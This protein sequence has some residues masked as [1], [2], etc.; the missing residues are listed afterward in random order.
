[1]RRC[2]LVA[3]LILLLLSAGCFFEKT[4]SVVN[5]GDYLQ[6]IKQHTKV[7]IEEV[8]SEDGENGYGKVTLQ[9]PN[10]PRILAAIEEKEGDINNLPAG[11]L[12]EIILE[13][14]GES[15]YFLQVDAEAELI[16]VDKQWKLKSDE[17]VLEEYQRQAEALFDMGLEK[18]DP[19]V[20]ETE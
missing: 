5:D 2:L 19:I 16:R 10:M 13:Y 17:L 20:L 4:D 8:R 18:L 3:I 11:T 7:T 12:Q 9:V 6:T 1:M 15:T 14:M